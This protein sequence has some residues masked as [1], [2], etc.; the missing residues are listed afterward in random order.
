MGLKKEKIG[1]KTVYTM[2]I[3]TDTYNGNRIT[4]TNINKS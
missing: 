1:A 2:E 4:M 3:R